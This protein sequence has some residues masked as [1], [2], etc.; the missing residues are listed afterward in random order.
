MNVKSFIDPRRCHPPSY[1]R[2]RPTS[3]AKRERKRERDAHRRAAPPPPPAR[4]YANHPT[5]ERGRSLFREAN[6]Y[7]HPAHVCVSVC[8]CTTFDDEEK[9]DVSEIERDRTK[10]ERISKRAAN[11]WPRGAR[12]LFPVL[13]SSS[14][15]PSFKT[16]QHRLERLPRGNTIFPKFRSPQSRPPRSDN[17]RHRHRLA[18]SQARPARRQT[19]RE[20]DTRHRFADRG[21]AVK[22]VATSMI[23]SSPRARDDDGA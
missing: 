8:A 15:A 23:T 6:L 9:E 19:T 16:V 14:D 11:L 18:R 5:S 22:S 4:E 10:G 1:P 17:S 7:A 20:T 21:S 12:F 13:R 3:Y 2:A